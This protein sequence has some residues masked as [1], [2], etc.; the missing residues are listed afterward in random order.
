MSDF[1]DYL[2]GLVRKHLRQHPAFADVSRDAFD[3]YLA[4]LESDF[5]D[6]LERDTRA[7]R[8]D[9]YNEGYA[10]A[11]YDAARAA[12]AEMRKAEAKVG[13][14]SPT[15]TSTHATS[16]QVAN[17]FTE[18]RHDVRNRLQQERSSS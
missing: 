7:E 16:N 12:E 18:L 5:R 11:E 10:D 6:E 14:I 15:P 17:T 3:L 2:T 13:K 4:D 8:H 1:A 9:A